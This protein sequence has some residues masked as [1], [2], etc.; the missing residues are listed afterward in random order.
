[1]IAKHIMNVCCKKVLE[2]IPGADVTEAV[3]KR[4]PF[5]KSLGPVISFSLEHLRTSCG[6][7]NDVTFMKNVACILILNGILTRC[8]QRSREEVQAF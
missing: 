5:K 7:V 1:M 6:F 3:V 8:Q 4:S 2:N